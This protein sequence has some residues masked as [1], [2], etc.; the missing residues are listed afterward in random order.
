MLSVKKWLAKSKKLVL[1]EEN[2]SRMITG[3]KDRVWDQAKNLSAILFSLQS[4][5]L[6]FNAR[7]LLDLRADERPGNSLEK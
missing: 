2:L 7:L 5:Y 4:R 1:Y 3:P 6:H